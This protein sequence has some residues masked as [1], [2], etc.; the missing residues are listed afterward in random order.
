[1][2]FSAAFLSSPLQLLLVPPPELVHLSSGPR[3][4]TAGEG[5]VE[6]A[7]HLVKHRPKGGTVSWDLLTLNYNIATVIQLAPAL[8][9][10]HRLQYENP[11]LPLPY[12]SACN[13]GNFASCVYSPNDRPRLPV[14][15]P[16][17]SITFFLQSEPHCAQSS[18]AAT[19]PPQAHPSSPPDFNA[20]IHSQ[21]NSLCSQLRLCPVLNTWTKCRTFLSF[22]L[23]L[24]ERGCWSEG[25]KFTLCT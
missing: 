12:S 18:S 8:Y 20:T 7:L 23:S 4:N 10:A 2:Y 5:G 24:S 25:E 16:C 13:S 21:T 19:S 1:M 3:A 14:P 17:V 15:A 6:S 22:S 9:R 11:S